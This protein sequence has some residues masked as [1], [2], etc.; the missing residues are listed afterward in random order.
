MLPTIP[1]NY[2]HLQTPRPFSSFLEDL[3]SSLPHSCSPTLFIIFHFKSY[4]VLAFPFSIAFLLMMASST[5]L[6]H[7]QGHALNLVIISAT[8]AA[9]M[10]QTSHFSSL[11]LSFQ[12]IPTNN[13]LQFFHQVGTK[14]YNPLIPLTHCR[15]L[16]HA[17][18]ILNHVR[19]QGSS[20]QSLLFRVTLTLLH[21][22]Y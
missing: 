10:F 13:Q 7:S 2:S 3:D 16:T 12:L 22:S 11:P 9:I 1:L 20:L 6:H 5:H 18:S 19:I 17:T 8:I 15:S 14:S 21:L 4:G